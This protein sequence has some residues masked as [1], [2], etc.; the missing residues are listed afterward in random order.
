VSD[1]EYLEW[2]FL[3]PRHRALA[4]ELDIWSSEHLRSAHA[5]DVDA[6]C[7]ALVRSLGEAGWLTHAIAGTRYGGATASIPAAC[8]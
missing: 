3:E 1:R 5:A 6:E 7:R 4:L 2:P 8:V